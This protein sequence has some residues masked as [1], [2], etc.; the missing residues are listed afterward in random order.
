MDGLLPNKWNG[1]RGSAKLPL[2]PSDL[3]YRNFFFYGF[4]RDKVCLLPLPMTSE[5]LKV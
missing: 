3:R 5:T 2:R 4:V 1:H